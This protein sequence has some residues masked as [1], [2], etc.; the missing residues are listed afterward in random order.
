M[1]YPGKELELFDKANFWRK[2]IF[3]K[4]KKFI[5][6]DILEIGA[7][8]G[9]FTSTYFKNTSSI[10][11]SELDPINLEFLKK[12]F[13]KKNIKIVDKYIT[14]I[15]D[16]FDSIM[17][18]NVLEHIEKDEEEINNSL[19]ILNRNGMLIILVPAHQKLF[20]KFDKEI[21]HFRRYDLDF[22][23]NLK[24]QDAKIEKLYYLD[25]SGYFLYY[26]NKFFFKDESYPSAFKIFVWDKFFT[27]ISLFF[28]FLTNYKFGKNVLCVIK[29]IN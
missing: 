1:H 7:G 19:K 23:K 25:S 26:L 21:G 12:R 8:L 3:F 4:T 9:S 18:M 16:N 11:V 14:E 6:G 24:L 22:F 13:A 5:K 27:P 10:T 28:D 2:Y 29:K 15:N 20:S 17:Y